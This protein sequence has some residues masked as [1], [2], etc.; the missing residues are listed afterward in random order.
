M[1]M[2]MMMMRIARRVPR[3]RMMNAM[4]CWKSWRWLTVVRV[5]SLI[6]VVVWKLWHGRCGGGEGWLEPVWL[7]HLVWLRVV[8]VELILEL[9]L[10][11]V[12]EYRL[13]F[14]FCGV[15]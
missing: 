6:I 11:K 12:D 9:S 13:I 10:G 2:M 7:E 5:E 14:H 8:L 3:R 4:R 1:L 15:L